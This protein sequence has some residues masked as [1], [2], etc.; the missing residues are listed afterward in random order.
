MIKGLK[1]L[2]VLLS[3]AIAFFAGRWS[4]SY[5]ALKLNPGATEN[6]DAAWD[7]FLESQE[8]TRQY[9]LS[10]PQ[11]QDS[12]QAAA[13]GYRSLLFNL[14]GAIEL[15]LQDPDFPRFSRMPDLGSKSGLDNPDNEY[16]MALID[17]TQSYKITG[18]LTS[19]RR[20]YLQSVY[21]QPGVGEAGPGTFAGTVTWE[22]ISFDKTGNFT[23]HVS[24]DAPETGKSW[25]KT[26]KGVE[27]ILLRY[28]DKS[29]NGE[30]N[31]DWVTIERLCD[32]CPNAAEPLSAQGMTQILGKTSQSLH[33][34]TASWTGI[35]NQIWSIFP[36]NKM[37]A[38]RQ[39]P[40]GLTGQYSAFGKFDLQTDEALILTVPASN[41][42]YQSIQ[43]GNRWFHSLDYKHRQSSLTREQSR[44][45]PGKIMTF[46]IS[47]QD[48]EVWNWLD[49][50]GLEKGLIMMRWQGLAESPPS[51]F[52]VRKVK[53]VNLR[54]E[55]P[56]TVD[57][58]SAVERKNQIANRTRAIKLR[59]Q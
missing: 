56:Q 36:A 45:D 8:T 34:R 24:P 17:G 47:Q 5:T 13:E 25:L 39:T 55:L 16:K 58:I 51:K 33:D 59:F 43:L 10:Q 35:A 18:Q 27:T 15:S 30:I 23:V 50:G 28:T 46:V 3:I 12:P 2:L 52:T 14:A 48:P 20:I 42:D 29:W 11:Y 32:N 40:N 31:Q 7:G 26:D 22:D 19:G 37:S 44:M 53:F 57:N 49:P 41:A 21:G 1:W 4:Q 6:M 9:I 54:A 38:P